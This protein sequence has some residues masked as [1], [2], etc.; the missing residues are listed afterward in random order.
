[1]PSVMISPRR[2]MS[3]SEYITRES[4]RSSTSSS[5]GRGA[6]LNPA[7]INSERCMGQKVAVPSARTTKGGG[8]P[9]LLSIDAAGR[10]RDRPDDR[11]HD[12]VLD[13]RVEEGVERGEDLGGRQSRDGV[14]PDGAADLA[15]QR[16]RRRTLA[17]DVAHAEE[18][19]VFPELEDVVP[20]ASG[21]GAGHPGA[22]FG[23]EQEPLDDPAASRAAP[24][25]GAPRRRRARAG[26]GSRWRVPRPHGSPP[27]W[28]RTRRRPRRSARGRR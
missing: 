11:G 1:M 20:V 17:H 27:R 2:S 12:P 23:V 8:W 7:A 24:P 28:P 26:S 15:H 16:S 9:A 19:G 4:P 6:P 10:E 21:V 25:A 14:G 5:R 3:P 13:E 18:D 22:V